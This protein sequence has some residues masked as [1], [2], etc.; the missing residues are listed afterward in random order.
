VSRPR[1]LSET[2]RISDPAQP[3]K[4]GVTPVTGA[5][6]AVITP[7]SQGHLDIHRDCSAQG[8]M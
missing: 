2:V 5:T 7:A 6:T 8:Q 4:S 1:S 3:D